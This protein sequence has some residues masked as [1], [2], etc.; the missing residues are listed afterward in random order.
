[1][2]RVRSSVAAGLIAIITISAF[3]PG[4]CA[5]E[6]ALFEPLWILRPDSAPALVDP[7]A[8]VNDEQPLPLVSLSPSRA[9]PVSL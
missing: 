2:F 7:P 9:P 6:H 1:M 4:L 3:V 5:L 8:A